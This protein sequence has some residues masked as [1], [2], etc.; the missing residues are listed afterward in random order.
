MAG[1]TLYD[2]DL[3][4][5]LNELGEDKRRAEYVLIDRIKPPVV[6]NYIVQSGKDVENRETVSEIGIF[7]AIIS[8]GENLLINS[9]C[10]HILKT[11]TKSY[12]EGGASVDNA[13][14]YIDSP[15]LLD[16][17]D[18]LNII[19]VSGTKG[20]GSVSAFCESILRANDLKT[21]FLSSPALI[22]HRERIRINGLPLTREEFIE[23]F[24]HVYKKVDNPQILNGQRLIAMTAFH[25]FIQKR[26]DVVIMEVGIGGTYDYTNVIRRPVVT[27]INLIDFDHTKYLGDT[28]DKIAWHKAGICKPGRPAF[29]ITQ[30][31]EAMD[32]ILSRAKELKA[33][34]QLVPELDEYDWQGHPMKL[35]IA[36]D[37]QKRNASLAIQLCRAWME[38]HTLSNTSFENIKTNDTLKHSY[39]TAPA[40]KLSDAF[41]VGLRN[42]QWPGRTQI[43]KRENVTYYLDGAHTPISIKA[44]AEWFKS[45]CVKVMLFN[46]T[47][48]RDPRGLIEMLHHCN[49]SCAT[50]C[51][52]IV[53]INSKQPLL[54]TEWK[55]SL[56][57]A[58]DV[59]EKNR[60]VWKILDE[61]VEPDSLSPLPARPPRIELDTAPRFDCVKHVLQ[62]ISCG[63]DSRMSKPRSEDPTPL[64][65]IV[66]ADHV[67]VLVTGSLHL[68]GC[69]IKVL[70]L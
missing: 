33:P 29:T 39:P 27:G 61:K 18:G 10:G 36:G 51:P 60:Q 54:D 57:Y 55:I 38:E 21:G 26:V 16:D 1:D 49:F 15:F 47:G 12:K 24:F 53:D 43:I 44:C 56:E 13:F 35:G 41:I 20:K 59:C 17:L 65:S 48:D 50:F 40:F 22:E 32:T 69:V 70:E 2:E 8:Q 3:V 23:Y 31:K 66:E 19:H 4:S 45:R 30:S 67:Q 11:K 34:I 68:V 58:N 14:E 7:A 62:W 63:K 25:A 52:N 46:V 9:T 42:C 37:H 28:L 64:Q 6:K 5:K